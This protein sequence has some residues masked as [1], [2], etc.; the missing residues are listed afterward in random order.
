M[1]KI[2]TSTQGLSDS[3]ALYD[4]ETDAAI[5]CH[6]SSMISDEDSKGEGYAAIIKGTFQPY[7]GVSS[8]EDE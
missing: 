7:P 2:D 4:V 3:V 5:E 6:K 8:P 1:D